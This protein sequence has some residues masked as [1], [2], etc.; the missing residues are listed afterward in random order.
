MYNYYNINIRVIIGE[1]VQFNAVH[2]VRVV[3]SLEKLSDTA[4]IELPSEY[5]NVLQSE[6][7]TSI[8]KERLLDYIAVGDSVKIEA[9]YDGDL[10]TE[11]NGYIT[12]VGADI[13]TVLECEDEMYKLRKASELNK[14]FAKVSLKELLQFIASGYE[15]S[16]QDIQ[17]G[18]F[19]ITQAT[20]Y[21]VLEVLK[22]QF[23]IRSYFNGKVLTAGLPIDLQNDT[24]HT[25][26]FGRNIRKSSSLKYRSKTDRKCWIKAISMQKGD[27]KERAVYEF[28]DKGESTITLHAP[29][30]LDK[31]ALK[32]WA[33]DYYKSVVF[34]GYEGNLDCWAKPFTRAG[35]VA[36]IID[37][38]YF[39]GHRDGR[40]L[41][42]SVTTDINSS[43]GIKRQNKLSL[44]LKNG[45]V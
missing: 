22:Q 32:K 10:K 33:E 31:E 7:R 20:P 1:K 11:F 18:K 43:V 36:K 13:P 25:F 27:A 16:A 39:D 23:G 34:D 2:S 44:K 3:N 12:D 24:V 9:G 14:T 38:N 30:N 40:Y 8:A 6:Q 4:K 35:D 42:E 28:G 37:R 26:V 29:L 5:T 21:K 15:V 41:I 19:M 45:G 17:L